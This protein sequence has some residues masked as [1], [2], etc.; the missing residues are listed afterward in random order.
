MGAIQSTILDNDKIE[1]IET[2]NIKLAFP[3][4]PESKKLITWRKDE[5]EDDHLDKKIK[6][7]EDILEKKDTQIVEVEQAVIKLKNRADESSKDVD[8]LHDKTIENYKKTMTKVQEMRTN[9]ENIKKK[10][11]GLLHIYNPSISV[12]VELSANEVANKINSG[13][14]INIYNNPEVSASTEVISV[15]AAEAATE[16]ATE[17][18]AEVAAEE[19]AAEK[20]A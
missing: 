15:S 5:N 7:V 18:A 19:P 8:M 13:N 6:E 14:S 4:N 12:P 2:I 3:I 1:N 9:A 17:A 20:P 10:L 16:A 11:L